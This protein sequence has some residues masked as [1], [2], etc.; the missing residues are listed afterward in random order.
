M[1]TAEIL[2]KIKTAN[3]L[4]EKTEAVEQ[5]LGLVVVNYPA[6]ELVGSNVDDSLKQLID[7]CQLSASPADDKEVGPLINGCVRIFKCL[8]S[9]DVGLSRLVEHGACE[10]LCGL[11]KAQKDL[12]SLE[13]NSIDDE[14]LHILWCVSCSKVF[15]ESSHL[16]AP[17]ANSAACAAS[18]Y[19]MTGSHSETVIVALKILMNITLL[20]SARLLLLESGFSE[21][22]AI[23][24]AGIGTAA[25]KQ[26]EQALKVIYNMSADP[27]MQ[28]TMVEKGLSARLLPIIQFNYMGAE[29]NAQSA[30]AKLSHSAT[31]TLQNVAY[32]KD[33]KMAL[34][35]AGAAEALLTVVGRVCAGAAA[36]KARARAAARSGRMGM[37]S[38]SGW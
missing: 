31:K 29:A 9:A 3:S 30:L 7:F 28:A 33:T 37:G 8:A 26:Q 38:P 12:H 35:C 5:L 16:H 22:L 20:K 11:L 19:S 36:A 2:E 21:T 1:S 10:A 6:L 13:W 32:H 25:S 34:I 23:L 17:F 4:R 18:K 24:D 15:E 27:T 14:M